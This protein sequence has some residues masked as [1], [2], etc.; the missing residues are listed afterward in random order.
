MLSQGRGSK[1]HVHAFWCDRLG[2]ILSP[3]PVLD[4]RALTRS[5]R[6]RR[7]C[8]EDGCAAPATMMLLARDMRRC[9]SDLTLRPRQ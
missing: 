4:A 7:R 3:Q 2:R 8:G 1:L 5:S 6:L 9:V